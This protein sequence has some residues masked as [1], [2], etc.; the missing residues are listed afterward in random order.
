MMIPIVSFVTVGFLAA[1]WFQKIRRAGKAKGEMRK[2]AAFAGGLPGFILGFLLAIGVGIVSTQYQRIEVAVLGKLPA[3]V[4]N[5]KDY[6]L[7]VLGK[8]SSE[9]FFWDAAMQEFRFLRGK[10]V[11]VH[12]EDRI[13]AVL[14]KVID[15]I[16][17]PYQWW[18]LQ[19]R[20]IAVFHVRI[21]K[22]SLFTMQTYQ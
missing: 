11:F 18:A 22:G 6:F 12:E 5:D 10:A 17:Q 3:A 9:Y 1:L 21:P 4:P 16:P 14:E 2:T 15:V 13:G 8:G 20:S 19:T 7:G